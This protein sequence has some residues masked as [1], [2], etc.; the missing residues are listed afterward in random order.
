M[1]SNNNH[2]H[3]PHCGRTIH[4]RKENIFTPFTGELSIFDQ[5]I[6][7]TDAK[8]TENTS[9][10]YISRYCGKKITDVTILTEFMSAYAHKLKFNRVRIISREKFMS[11]TLEQKARLFTWI[12]QD[13]K[14]KNNNKQKAT[15][16]EYT[17]KTEA[18]KHY[19]SQ[20]LEIQ[21]AMLNVV[22]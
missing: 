13:K 7:L 4:S 15:K 3:C 21:S 6:I 9:N 8:R 17:P 10:I 19:Y 18:E 2:E 1:S 16:K 12:Q 14:K 11:L 22:E 20:L 5:W